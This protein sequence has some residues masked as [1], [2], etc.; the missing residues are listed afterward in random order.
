MFIDRCNLGKEQRDE[1]VNL[2]GGGHVDVHAVVLDLPAK[3]CISRSVKQTG[4]EGNLQGG[5]AAA[6]VNRMLKKKQ[7][8]HFIH[9]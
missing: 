4:H 5:K 3:V 6:V 8:T 9:S 1:V 2:G 7:K